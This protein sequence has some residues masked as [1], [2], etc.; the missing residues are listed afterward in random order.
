M[1]NV[2]L[3][4]VAVIAVSACNNTD[5]KNVAN[6]DTT[7]VVVDST[8]APVF[9]FEKEVYEFGKIKQ[10]ESVSY[11]FKFENTG[12][13]PLIIKEATATCGCT[14]PE[15]PKEPIPVGGSGEIKVTFNSEGKEGM[16]DKVVTII[17]NTIPQN[18]E[19]HLVGEIVK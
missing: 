15:F 10:G 19:V 17:A 1:K 4:L 12:K 6:G 14:V 8:L 11:N 2:F 13:S 9:N 7:S 5:V 3:G 18:T 16:Q